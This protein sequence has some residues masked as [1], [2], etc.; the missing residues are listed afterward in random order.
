M[1]KSINVYYHK[2]DREQL[3]KTGI[4]PSIHQLAE[5]GKIKRYY[6]I[7]HWLK[8]PH[9]GINLECLDEFVYEKDI[10]PVLYENIKDYLFKKPSEALEDNEMTATYEQLSRME[11]IKEDYLPLIPTNS[12]LEVPYK[13]DSWLGEN[14]SKIISDYHSGTSYFVEKILDQT[15]EELYPT[16]LGMMLGVI[17]CVKDIR[18]SYLSFRSHS[19]AMLHAYDKNNLIRTKFQKKYILNQLLIKD[20]IAQVTEMEHSTES[21][22]EFL[23]EWTVYCKKF[24]TELYKEVACGNVFPPK[25]D[26]VVLY[27]Q[28]FGAPETWIVD[29]MSEFHQMFYRKNDIDNLLNSD[30]FK[31]FRIILSLL[32]S[33]FSNLGI[34]PIERFYL[35]YLVANG[36]EDFYGIDWKSL[37]EEERLNEI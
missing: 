28:E 26:E 10:K 21:N 31:S 8:G 18:R 27:F 5:S 29:E 33:T 19:E 13:K 34:K 14:G 25:Q 36:V 22:D 24:Y 35:C 12:I 3:I 4:L 7:R 2:G 37:F 23:Q 1:W 15:E 6:F 9:V 16:L 30:T 20:L 11:L 32:Y 17:V